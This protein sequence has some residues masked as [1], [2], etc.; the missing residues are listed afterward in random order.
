MARLRAAAINHPE[1]LAGMPLNFHTVSAR[2]RTSWTTSS[3]SARLWSPNSRVS[4][5]TIRPASWR[6]R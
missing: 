4:A 1:G 5:D 2:Q 6:N 3:A